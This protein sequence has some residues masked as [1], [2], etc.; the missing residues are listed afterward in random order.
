[1]KTAKIL[2][3]RAAHDGRRMLVLVFGL[4]LAIAA[5]SGAGLAA[6][7]EGVRLPDTANVAGKQLVLNGIG[8]RQATIFHVNV[9]VAG[10]YVV[11]RSSDPAALLNAQDPKRLEMVFVRDVERDK[12]VE[13]FTEGF[14]KNAGGRVPSLRARI[15]RLNGWMVDMKRGSTLTLTYVPG[16][17]VEVAVNGAV[18]GTIEGADFATGL[19]SI[20]L[21]PNPPN[22]GLKDGLLGRAS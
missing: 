22:A 18:R 7:R 17:G 21:G 9:Y 6:E 5:L 15:D 2:G 16:V 10:L 14:E 8:I 12:I 3:R 11:R 1:M 13:A 19:F 4:V 20:W